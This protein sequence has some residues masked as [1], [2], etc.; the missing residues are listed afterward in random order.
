[1]ASI[2]LPYPIFKI[3]DM[4]GSS[5]IPLSFL[6]VGVMLNF[7][8]IRGS[9]LPLMALTV[10]LRMMIIPLLLLFVL[11]LLNVS[12]L[13]TGVAVIMLGTPSAVLATAFAEKF[14]GNHKLAAAGVLMTTTVAAFSIPMLIALMGI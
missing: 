4:V 3:F 13:V 14:G 8:V 11:K 12:G 9:E 1:M 5:T 2:E 6:L 7:T 10:A